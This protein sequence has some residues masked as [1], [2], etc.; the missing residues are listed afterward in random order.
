MKV[1]FILDSKI[2]S[3]DFQQFINFKEIKAL[4][5][6]SLGVCVK[7]E[8]NLQWDKGGKGDSSRPFSFFF[9]LL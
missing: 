2:T 8:P 3:E 1:S 6:K 9:F 7:V 4:L 5:G